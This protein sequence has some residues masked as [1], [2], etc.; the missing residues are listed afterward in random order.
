MM[1]KDIEFGESTSTQT[2]TN[3]NAVR[4]RKAAT[5]MLTS[6]NIIIS[7]SASSSRNNNNHSHGKV[8]PS[9]RRLKVPLEQQSSQQQFVQFLQSTWSDLKG[10]A[11]NDPPMMVIYVFLFA[12]LS[13][14]DRKSVV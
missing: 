5:G 7:S 4:S 6:G 11:T 10:I 3:N 1:K 9:H 13:V 8:V 14:I 2:Q 12:V